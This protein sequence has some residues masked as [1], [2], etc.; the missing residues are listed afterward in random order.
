MRDASGRPRFVPCDSVEVLVWGLFKHGFTVFFTLEML[1]RFLSDGPVGYFKDRWNHLDFVLVWLAIL[2]NW[3]LG[4]LLAPPPEE[5]MTTTSAKGSSG[6]EE[7]GSMS[8]T[9]D[10]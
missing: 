6:E 5:G 8:D 7:K 1:L 2:D 9:E 4:L 10:A 3:I